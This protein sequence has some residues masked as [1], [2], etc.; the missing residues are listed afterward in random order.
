MG[1]IKNKEVVQNL[2]IEIW[3]FFLFKEEG[4]KYRMTHIQELSSENRLVG[5][6]G[7]KLKVGSLQLLV[8]FTQM[9]HH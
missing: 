2:D 3:V 1:D 9:S 8:T 4:M 5:T 7:V 6:R